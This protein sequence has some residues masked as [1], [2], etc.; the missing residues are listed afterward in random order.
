MTEVI[1]CNDM[2]KVRVISRDSENQ[3]QRPR[4]TGGPAGITTS[5]DKLSGTLCDSTI[6]SG[7]V[8]QPEAGGDES[9]RDRKGGAK[10]WGLMGVYGMDGQVN[11]HIEGNKGVSSLQSVYKGSHRKELSCGIPEEHPP[12]LSVLSLCP[13]GY[14]RTFEEGFHPSALTMTWFHLSASL[15]NRPCALS[16]MMIHT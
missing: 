10:G 12:R 9:L 3:E 7:S 6:L 8:H 2:E 15:V 11:Q 1:I 4:G 14:L 5:K 13:R 16:P